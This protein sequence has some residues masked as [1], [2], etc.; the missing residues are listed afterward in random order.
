MKIE[1]TDD[2]CLMLR[3]MTVDTIESI[4]GFLRDEGW[5]GLGS[6]IKDYKILSSWEGLVHTS[7]LVY[8][9]SLAMV[10]FR[11]IMEEPDVEILA[12][13]GNPETFLSC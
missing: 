6:P 10:F 13:D 12:P 2:R 4:R 11:T 5:T 9:E 1:S 8:D 3:G 7:K